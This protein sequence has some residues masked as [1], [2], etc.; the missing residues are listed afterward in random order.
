MEKLFK[1]TF[2]EIKSNQQL[3]I[4]G[5]GKEKLSSEKL[6]TLFSIIN[7]RYENMLPTITYTNL[8]AKE[9]IA[10]ISDGAESEVL[11]SAI[12]GRIWEMGVRG[13]GGTMETC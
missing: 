4:T 5:I 2:S 8:K 6:G 3:E 7:Y 10:A 13:I 1:R 9:L 11:A 12:V